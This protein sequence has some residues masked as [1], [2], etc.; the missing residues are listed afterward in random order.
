[1]LFKLTWIINI[2]CK[3]WIFNGTLTQKAFPNSLTSTS[4]QIQPSRGV[5]ELHDNTFIPASIS[6]ALSLSRIPWHIDH[7]H[8]NRSCS[9]VPTR[10]RLLKE[11]ELD[12]HQINLLST[13]ICLLPVPQND[14]VLFLKTN[15]GARPSELVVDA[16]RLCVREILVI[17]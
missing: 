3:H 12:L 1:M 6:T 7:K 13:N 5:I 8:L 14:S 15:A 10:S 16:G 17:Y 11:L 2:V 4:T 9:E